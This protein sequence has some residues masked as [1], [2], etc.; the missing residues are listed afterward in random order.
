MSWSTLSISVSSSVALTPHSQ[1]SRPTKMSLYL[2]VWG[3]TAQ[4]YL[5]RRFTKFLFQPDYGQT[6][7]LENGN[8]PS[9]SLLVIP[10]SIIAARSPTVA[11]FNN[12]TPK[13]KQKH[14][15]FRSFPVQKTILP[16]AGFARGV[17]YR[18]RAHETRKELNLVLCCPMFSDPERAS[19]SPRFPG[20]ADPIPDVCGPNYRAGENLNISRHAFFFRGANGVYLFGILKWVSG[21]QFLLPAWH[22]E[23]VAE[24]GSVFLCVPFLFLSELYY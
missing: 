17:W 19:K 9:T 22:D 24:M 7:C 5:Y 15:V 13:T 23:P 11:H 4:L 20:N 1:S 16:R 12:H 2:N 6:V 10:W 8:S 18:P 14:L 3:A 21:M